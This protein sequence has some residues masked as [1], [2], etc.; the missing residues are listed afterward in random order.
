MSIRLFIC[1]SIY[2]LFDATSL[3]SIFLSI[4]LTIYLCTFLCLTSN[5]SII[6]CTFLSLYSALPISQSVLL[7]IHYRSISLPAPFRCSVHVS[8]SLLLYRS[9]NSTV[10]IVNVLMASSVPPPAP[11]PLPASIHLPLPPLFPLSTFS[12]PSLQINQ[13]NVYGECPH[14]L[15][16]PSRGT[17]APLGT[18]HLHAKYSGLVECLDTR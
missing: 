13:Y 2:S 1:L 3:C 17:K 10:H 9:M 7:E 11:I 18:S 5:T 8:R 12:L 16:R 14:E 4:F 15:A 6:C